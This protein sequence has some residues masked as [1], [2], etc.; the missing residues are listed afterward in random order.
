MRLADLKI[1]T[2]IVS[3]IILLG[4]VAGGI[5]VLGSYGLHQVT[6]FADHLNQSGKKI[7]LGAQAYI[8]ILSISRG[9]YRA[10]AAPS[11]IDEIQSIIPKYKSQF[12]ERLTE[13]K[14]TADAEQR[15]QIDAIEKSYAEYESMSAKTFALAEKQ[16]N[17]VQSADQREIYESVVAARTKATEVTDQITKLNAA[18]SA[19]NDK[20]DEEAKSLSGALMQIMVIG[21]LVGIITGLALGLFVSKKGVVEP[22][23]SIR[24]CL[25]KLA[26][27]QLQI[28]IYGVDRKDEIGEIAQTT[29]VFKDNMIKAK[30][31]DAAQRADA[32]AKARRGERIAKLVHDFE[33][34]IKSIIATVASSATELQS[35]AS[36]MAATAQQ[37][38]QQ[39][40]TV[41]AASQEASANVQAVAGATEEMSVST[42]EI[43]EQVTK[44]SQMASEAVVQARSTKDSVGN[45]SQAS[46]KIGEV[47]KLIQSIAGQ[48]NLLALNATIE[49]ARAGDLGKGFAVVA[50]EVK[51]LA[52][53]TARATEEIAEQI[54]DIQHATASTVSAIDVIDTSIGRISQVAGAV[55][56][57]VHEQV[58]ATD[59]ISSNVQQAAKGTDE[60]SANIN[61][62]AQAASQTGEAAEMVLTAATELSQEAEHLKVEVDSF[63]SNLNAA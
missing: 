3:V 57:A 28:D 54:S 40:A 5:A 27:G 60:I 29:L 39:G 37:T 63:L 52:S 12:S 6:A 53:Q 16:K 38:Q 2:K 35:S 22:I 11:E 49:A 61:G 25:A 9:E 62:V 4:I 23:H 43:G 8:A 51:A 21:A 58:A 47:V 46:E 59:E 14:Q 17:A 55:A 1:S 34:M 36:S 13:L 45:L 7:R 32:E 20:I 48:T 26:E 10:A 33:A 44:A 41:A 30:E 15:A 56:A 18:L 50:N 19:Q 24:D 42:K 31:L